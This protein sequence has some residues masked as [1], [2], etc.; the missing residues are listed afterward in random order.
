MLKYKM[1]AQIC[2]QGFLNKAGKRSFQAWR[3]RWFNL[4]GDS[5]KYYNPDTTYNEANLLGTI[6]M[7]EM[8]SIIPSKSTKHGF[9]II[10]KNRT[11]NVSAKTDTDRDDWI[12]V[13]RKAS[14]RKRGSSDQ[15]NKMAD[16]NYEQLNF[17]NDKQKKKKEAKKM[18]SSTK[19]RS[20]FYSEPADSSTVPSKDVIGKKDSHIYNDPYD[21]V[22]DK[23]RASTMI[24]DLGEKSYMHDESKQRSL[25]LNDQIDENPL[26]LNSVS[27]KFGQDEED[28]NY[29]DFYDDLDKQLD[30]EITDEDELENESVC[31][32]EFNLPPPLENNKKHAFI[33]IK[34]LLDNNSNT[35]ELY[36]ETIY[37]KYT[38]T[39]NETDY[40]SI[41]LLKAVLEK[42]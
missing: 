14:N 39:K 1:E 34:E 23:P 4:N 11:Y 8:Q 38:I 20:S 30:D 15:L 24:P 33:E 40:P 26:S 9:D 27:G 19:S 37:S 7:C 32:S 17:E 31:I 42:F 3:K 2:K 10:T 28:S 25:S 36:L 13:L 35:N 18:K 16:N 22:A 6:E 29:K 21:S 12:L 41:Y 5:L